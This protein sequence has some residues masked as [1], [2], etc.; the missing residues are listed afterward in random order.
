MVDKT[1]QALEKLLALSDKLAEIDARREQERR[2]AEQN[3]TQEE[4]KSEN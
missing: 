4:G 2:E 1:K 3:T